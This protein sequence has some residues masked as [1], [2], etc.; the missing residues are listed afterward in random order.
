[1]KK[2]PDAL[3]VTTLHRTLL[4][5][6]AVAGAMYVLRPLWLSL[7][8]QKSSTQFPRRRRRMISMTPPVLLEPLV[9]FIGLNQRS[10]SVPKRPMA[11]TWSLVTKYMWLRMCDATSVKSRSEVW[12]ASI[13][14][15]SS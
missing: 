14:T 7:P 13:S 5:S 15:G 1:M 11:V 9:T 6:L 4:A 10:K 12:F 8:S 2:P 3:K